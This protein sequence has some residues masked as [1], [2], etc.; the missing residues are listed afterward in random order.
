MENTEGSESIKLLSYI[1][2]LLE[3]IRDNT[4]DLSQIKSSA[5]D[6]RIASESINHYIKQKIMDEE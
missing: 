3:Q 6:I 1:S 5:E 2:E 4:D